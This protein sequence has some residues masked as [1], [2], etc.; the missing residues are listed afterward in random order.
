MQIGVLF[1]P[2]DLPAATFITVTVLSYKRSYNMP[3]PHGQILLRFI[4]NF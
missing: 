2:A 4:W 3:S 1:K